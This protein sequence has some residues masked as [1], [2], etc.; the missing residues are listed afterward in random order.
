MAT[1][2]L[3][4]TPIG[5]LEDITLRALRILRE[6]SLIAA[7]DTRAAGRLLKRYEI[8]TP[9]ISYHDF[10]DAQRL[11]QLLAALT[12]GDVAL[13]SEAGMPAL[14]DPGYRLV[15]AAVAAGIAISPIPGPSAIVAALAA[16]GLPTDSFLFLGF[17]P[18]QQKK[19]RDALAAVANLPFTLVLFEAPH[20]FRALLADLLTVLGDRPLA[21]GR[22]MTKLYEEIWRGRVSEAQTAFP[23]ERVR[24]EFTLVVG[25]ADPAD[26]KW[27][28]QEVRNALTAQLD[29]GLSRKEAAA[30][31]A[32]QSGWRPRDVYDLSLRES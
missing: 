12:E 20:R 11:E 14:S 19:R 16:S 7:E 32:A 5:N 30:A 31:V 13:V 8:E 24:G 2:Y 3:V 27:D 21:V 22:E 25:G 4:G 17:L 28:E 18:R 29:R 6:V 15:T 1:L 26:A 9:L 10:S 23:P